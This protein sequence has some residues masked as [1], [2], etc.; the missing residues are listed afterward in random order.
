MFCI[1]LFQNIPALK[2]RRAP[3][4]GLLRQADV[5]IIKATEQCQGTVEEVQTEA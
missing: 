3:I 2:G 1:Q 5:V 4:A